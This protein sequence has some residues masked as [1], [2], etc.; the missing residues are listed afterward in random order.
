MQL[1]IS[2]TIKSEYTVKPCKE[3]MALKKGALAPQMK[4]TMPKTSHE[5]APKV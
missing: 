5:E 4:V 3:G 2:K 1:P